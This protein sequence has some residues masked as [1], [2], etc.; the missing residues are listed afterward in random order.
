MYS[1][2]ITHRLCSINLLLSYF[3]P[4]F[5][6]CKLAQKYSKTSKSEQIGINQKR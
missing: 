2:L 6:A 1:T 3:L 4:K 5:M